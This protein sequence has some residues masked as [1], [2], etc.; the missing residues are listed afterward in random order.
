M[1]RKSLRN[2][3]D[4]EL[5]EMSA[6][7]ERDAFAARQADRELDRREQDSRDNRR[8]WMNFGCVAASFAIAVAVCLTGLPPAVDWWIPRIQQF[9]HSLGY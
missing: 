9:L 6:N 3:T 1:A 4:E 5:E 8:F 2:K 7:Y